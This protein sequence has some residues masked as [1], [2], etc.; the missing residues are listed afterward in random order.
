MDFPTKGEKSGSDISFVRD[1]KNAD[2]S[3]S[4]TIRARL[5]RKRGTRN[6]AILASNSNRFST[7]ET[8]S[9]AEAE[10]LEEAFEVTAILSSFLDDG[11]DTNALI[12][13]RSL[14]AHPNKEVRM[15]AL[16]AMRWIGAAAAADMVSFMGDV[17]PEISKV[18]DEA[19]WDAID[20]IEDPVLKIKVL[21]PSLGST[22]VELRLEALEMLIFLP[23]YLS[24][25]VIAGMLDDP[26]QEVQDLA[27]DNLEFISE[28]QFFSESQ[29]MSW[30]A[31]HKKEL[32]DVGSF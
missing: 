17:D 24:F 31:Q 5:S 7:A 15:A 3:D 21:E 27:R 4:A 16:E 6:S 25:P 10:Q 30:F 28:E 1:K 23:E 26:A 20:E 12:E 32:I 2:K 22:S 29:A 13:A 9:V 14:I 19:F 8:M 18:A 11:D